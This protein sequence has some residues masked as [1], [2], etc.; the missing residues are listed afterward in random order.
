MLLNELSIGQKASI[1][2]ISYMPEITDRLISMGLIKGVVIELVRKA[3]LGDPIE[4]KVTNFLL[5]L[6][7]N[8]ASAIE[9]EEI[10]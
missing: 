9:V 1:K 4:I 8:E 5:S 7:R 6:R 10:S 2:K 3:P